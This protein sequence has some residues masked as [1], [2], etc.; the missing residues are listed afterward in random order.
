MSQALDKRRPE[1]TLETVQHMTGYELPQIALVRTKMAVSLGV[2]SDKVSLRDVL[3]Y[4]QAAQELGLSPLL[5]QIH[6]IARGGKASHQVGI[7]GLRAIAD[8]SGAYAGSDPPVFRGELELDVGKEGKV[9]V[10]EMAQVL[11]RKIVQGRVCSFTGE[12]YWREFYPS[13]EQGFMYRKMPRLM[14]AKDAEAQALR[15][16]FPAQLGAVP[17]SSVDVT[18]M[19]SVA[20]DEAEREAHHRA[21]YQRIYGDDKQ[22][23]L[24]QQTEAVVAEEDDNPGESSGA[25]AESP[26]QDAAQVEDITTPSAWERHRTLAEQAAELRIR[27]RTLRSDTSLEDV[28][29]YNSELEERIHMETERRRSIAR[30]NLEKNAS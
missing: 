7:D 19:A 12:A 26:P 18:E 17:Y 30:Q 13:G 4:I 6:W 16:A 14:L 15:K 21:E 1:V 11:V 27:V 8:R 24:P 29:S 22:F 25:T 28:E 20:D 3:L 2:E 10:P 5:N 23:Q 9:R